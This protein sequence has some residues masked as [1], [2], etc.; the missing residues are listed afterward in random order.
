MNSSKSI[1]NAGSVLPFSFDNIP[2]RGKIITIR[3]AKNFIPSVKNAEPFIKT[4]LQECLTATVLFQQ[5]L[6]SEQSL[7]MQIVS[8]SSISLIIAQS[9]ANGTI[10]AY[11]DVK[12]D[13]DIN[14]FKDFAKNSPKII[15]TLENKDQSYQSIIPINKASLEESIVDYYNHSAQ[16]KTYLKFFHTENTICALMLQHMPTQAQE[17]LSAD[18]WD[19]V[20]VMAKSLKDEEINTLLNLEIIQRLFAEDTIRIYEEKSLAF[21]TQSDRERMKNAIKSL[22]LAQ[23]KEL[24]TDGNIEMI[25]QFSGVKESFNKEDIQQ[26]FDEYKGEKMTK[27]NIN[28]HYGDLPA[29]ITFGNEIAMDCEMMGLNPIRDKLCLVQISDNGQD[30]HLVKFD[31]T[32]P[33]NSPNLVKVLEDN[34]KIKIFH[35]ARSDMSTLIHHLNAKPQNIYCTKIASKLCRTYT[36]KHSLKYVL[37]ELMDVTISKAQQ[38]SNWGAEELTQEQLE[39]A[40]SD[41]EYLHQIKTELDKKVAKLGRSEL[42]TEINHF[43]PTLAKLDNMGYDETILNHH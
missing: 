25:D 24:L 41:V 6:K 28:L 26:I 32:K 37:E 30:V 17:E 3:D 12:E 23:V 16:I 8:D 9:L 20:Q 31:I 27:L 38:L 40:A 1:T 39:Y 36:D 43:I 5:D 14:S 13:N 18:D 22:G 19:R 4:L 2:L 7:T 42:L 33:Y 29:N 15:M 34:S 11:A 35:F 10:K 21:Y